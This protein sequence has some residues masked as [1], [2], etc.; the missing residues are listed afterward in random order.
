VHQRELV[1]LSERLAI[2]LVQQAMAAKHG[3]FQARIAGSIPGLPVSI[4]LNRDSGDPNNRHVLAKEALKAAAGEAGS[5][6][7]PG[8]Y[9]HLEFCP[10]KLWVF[11]FKAFPGTPIAVTYA[12]DPLE[13]ELLILI[14]SAGNVFG[15]RTERQI[16]GWLPSDPG[17]LR[18]L[19]RYG[20][21]ADLDPAIGEIMDPEVNRIEAELWGKEPQD[22]VYD[23]VFVAAQITRT[24]DLN[25]WAEV[26]AKVHEY[27][28]DVDVTLPVR[29]YRTVFPRVVVGA[30]VLIR[31]IEAAPTP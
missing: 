3:K 28:D 27:R 23:A 2:D 19:G 12:H 17:G 11:S 20:R 9:I 10:L 14:G 5:L 15:Y 26:L 24:P 29:G 4:S 22:L 6:E 7:H 18:E 30:P 25:C 13:R 21:E 1:Y 31:S 16:D 8:R